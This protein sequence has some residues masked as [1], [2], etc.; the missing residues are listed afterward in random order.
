[1]TREGQ[2][3]PGYSLVL[4]LGARVREAQR[5]ADRKAV[6]MSSWIGVVSEK[7]T[8]RRKYNFKKKTIEE[9]MKFICVVSDS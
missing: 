6:E 3:R 4:S 8:E 7:L 2:P 9:N 5:P 1:M